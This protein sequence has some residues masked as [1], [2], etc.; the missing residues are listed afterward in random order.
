MYKYTPKS[1]KII[2]EWSLINHLEKV[3]SICGSTFY[4]KYKNKEIC[5]F[6][7][8]MVRNNRNSIS[9]YEE[10]KRLKKR[11][12]PPCESCGYWLSEI[13]HSGHDKIYRLCPNCHSS[14]T[15]GFF[16]LEQVLN[17]ENTYNPFV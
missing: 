1:K 8:S 7:C 10:T 12:T 6:D 5:S 16:T 11:N 4:T 13:H 2:T 3:C 15:R 14:I 9:C 17:K